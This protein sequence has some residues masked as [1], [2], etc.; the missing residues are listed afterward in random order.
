[1]WTGPQSCCNVSFA[2]NRDIAARVSNQTIRSHQGITKIVSTP[3]GSS[4]VRSPCQ[5]ESVRFI[6]FC[7]VSFQLIRE[8]AGCCCFPLRGFRAYWGQI[9]FTHQLYPLSYSRPTNLFHLG[10]REHVI[11]PPPET[12]GQ[13]RLPTQQN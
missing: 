2:Q 3:S 6:S 13:W 10:K 11:K 4:F 7:F 12:Q 1:M 8:V 5:N 9:Q